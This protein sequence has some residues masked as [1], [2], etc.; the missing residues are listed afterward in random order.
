[1]KWAQP[2]KLALSVI[3]MIG[4]RT[5]I[6]TTIATRTQ[7]VH[8]RPRKPPT[9]VV[10]VGAFSVRVQVVAD[11]AVVVASSSHSQTAAVPSAVA[12]ATHSSASEAND[13]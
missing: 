13:G 1:M 3:A 12:R 7:T 4:L 2:M 6:A 8:W 9:A 5:I 10:A 11:V